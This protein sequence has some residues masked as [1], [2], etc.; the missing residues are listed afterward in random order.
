MTKKILIALA[1]IVASALIFFFHAVPVSSSV[2]EKKT[3][4]EAVATT[5]PEIVVPRFTHRQ[6]TW[7]SALEWCESK[8][9]NTAVN[10][11]DKDGTPSYYA[12]Q[13]KPSTFRW[14]GE[15]YGVIPK[16]KTDAEIME[17]LK[18]YSLQR[19][20]VEF[21]VED[22]SVRWES[23]FPGCI[24]QLGRPPIEISN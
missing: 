9:D 11:Y 17:L 7:I 6:L 15:T 18:E 8:A 3:E 5:T 1:L 4:P 22:P 19:A 23:E 13:F 24:R 2:A 10:W 14:R 12:F 21:M 20:I 16:G